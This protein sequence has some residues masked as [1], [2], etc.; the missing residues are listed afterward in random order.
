MPKKAKDEVEL[1]EVAEVTVA[2][3]MSLMMLDA[4]D[5]SE[6]TGAAVEEAEAAAVVRGMETDAKLEDA[7]ADDM[8]L[9]LLAAAVLEVM[10][11]GQA[12]P[13]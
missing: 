3:R 13:M 10:A 1:A 9:L 2:L 4:T 12:V 6:E 5:K 8:L 11:C 7:A